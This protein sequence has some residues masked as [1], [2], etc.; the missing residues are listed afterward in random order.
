MTSRV[1]NSEEK[2]KQIAFKPNHALTALL[3]PVSLQSRV[4]GQMD[5]QLSALD[6]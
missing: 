5:H 4:S 3:A 2:M 6:F 1:I